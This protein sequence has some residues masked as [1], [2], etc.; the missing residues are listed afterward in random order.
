MAKVVPVPEGL[1]VDVVVS[2]LFEENCYLVRV[3]GSRT[4]V[5][6]D[7]GLDAE[8]VAELVTSRQLEVAA[9]L[10]T[11]GHADHI[12]GNEFLKRCWPGAELVIGR[13][14]ASKLTDPIAN[15]SA[16]FGVSLISPPA[17]RQVV[18][19]EELTYGPL[20]LLVQAAP[21]HSRGH[22]VFSTEPT[23]S[24]AAIFGG[25]VLFRESVG[26]TDFPDGDA[27]ALAASIRSVFYAC[28]DDTIV[29]PGHGPPTTVGHEK[30]ANPFVP[31]VL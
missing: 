9:I 8:S 4:A 19:G 27:T 13:D 25:D 15:L 11:H 30:R 20:R 24:P 23:T 18:G 6:I 31:G 14:D 16:P 7:P 21:G 12:A 5:V 2:P 3:A 1:E 26:R 28:P 10:N 17:D 22:V 29:Y